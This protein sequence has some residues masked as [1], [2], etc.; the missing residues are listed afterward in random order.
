LTHRIL[1]L[2]EFLLGNRR[3]ALGPSELVTAILVPQ[4]DRDER[5]IFLKLGARAYLVISIASVA[6]NI[7]LD[8]QGRIARARIAVGACSAVPQRLGALEERLVGEAPEAASRAV[9]P[10][11]LAALSPI[12]DVR[13]SAAYRLEAALMLVRRALDALAEPRSIAA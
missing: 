9:E 5:S 7:A 3:T 13:A 6:A 12:D 8:A 1:P 10:V 4:P 11:M 2:S